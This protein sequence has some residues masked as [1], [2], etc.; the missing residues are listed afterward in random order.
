MSGLI[1]R[2]AVDGR[3]GVV[4]PGSIW[5]MRGARWA[6]ASG[7]LRKGQSGLA[8]VESS[9][10]S[11]W[12]S[13]RPDATPI[14]PGQTAAIISRVSGRCWSM[15]SAQDRVCDRRAGCLA[16]PRHLS[17]SR[18]VGRGAN[19]SSNRP[20]RRVWYDVRSFSRP[21]HILT[22]SSS[23]G[24]PAAEAVPCRQ[25]A[26]TMRRKAV[27]SASRIDWSRTPA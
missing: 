6:A 22:K 8:L 1:S 21:Q 15:C 9:S 13:A 19:S 23:T 5:I 20:R 18:Q 11:G 7:R 12:A 10:T 4:P 14:A 16:L 25:S 17:G 26:V 2:P 27:K 3:Q 24:P